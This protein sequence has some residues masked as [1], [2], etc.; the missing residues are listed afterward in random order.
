MHIAFD[1]LVHLTERPEQVKMAFEQWGLVAIHGGRH[2]SWGTYNALCYVEHLRY[3][4]WIG[5]AD[6][7]TARTC[8]NP[9]I[10]QLVADRQEGKRL[11]PVCLSHERHR[12]GGGAAQKQ[13][14][15][16]SR[17]APRQPRA[18]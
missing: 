1:H 7:Q 8:G 12:S 5:I 15:R 4:E 6:I 11:L 16:P 10:T 2:P 9:L 13:R 18:R 14:I 17:S 3:I